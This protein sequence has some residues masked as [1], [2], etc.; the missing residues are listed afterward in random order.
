MKLL[1]AN[2]GEIALRI[3]R[4]C[5]KLGVRTVAVYSEPDKGSLPLRY[6]DE[7]YPLRGSTPTD[8]Y[9][10]IPKLI[11]AAKETNCDAVHPGYGFLSEDERFVRA[12]EENNLAFIG[13]SSAALEKLANKLQA[14]KTMKDAD[15][16]VIPGS[17]GPLKDE[18][19]A[20]KVAD[21]IGYPVILKAVYGGGGRGMRVANN[22]EEARRFFRIT[23][24]ES[25]SAFG[26]D[27]IYIEKRLNNPRH[28][29]I[30][31]IAD[32]HG[33]IV[34]LGE[35]ECSIQRRHQKLLEEAPSVA[36]DESLRSQISSAATEGLRASGYSN[37]GTVEFLLE[38]TGKFYFLEV[39]K[40][41]QVEHLVTELTTGLDIVEEQLKIAATSNLELSQ[42][43][44]HVKGW[45]IDCRINAEDPRRNFAPSPG[46]VFIYHPP[47]GPGIRVDS[48][49]FS[50]CEIPEFYD[51]LIA[52]LSVYGANRSDA[53][54]RMKVA[55][56]EIEI[57]GIPTTVPL[58][59]ELMRDERFVQGQFDTTYLNTILPRLQSTINEFEKIAAVVAAVEK[60][61]KP[62]NHHL[63]KAHGPTSRWRA[64]A[65]TQLTSG[66]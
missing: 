7:R 25:R 52:K 13:P 39:N 1:I 20:A 18:D 53:I 35:R 38:E 24:L 10:N 3:I 60:T 45:A 51:S 27:E 66:K 12:C 22:S 9:L 32:T 59:R 46:K 41:L 11:N 33:K 36:L 58:H 26:R 62:P 48:A 16:P 47:T 50:G 21:S 31:A 29:E 37:A 54:S 63:K 43:E 8:T 44:V 40:R 2:R 19:D 17:D 55:L 57:L 15:V 49:L 6:A 14:R 65:R 30:Q 42:N 34:S 61:N 23:T 28:I 56:D 5:R 4:T 64:V